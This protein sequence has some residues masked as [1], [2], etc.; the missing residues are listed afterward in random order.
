MFGP[1]FCKKKINYIKFYKIKWLNDCI[2]KIIFIKQEFEK[3]ST[4]NK[5]EIKKYPLELSKKKMMKLD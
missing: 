2:T 4:K 1:L 3:L 5:T